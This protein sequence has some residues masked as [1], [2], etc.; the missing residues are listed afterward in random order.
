MAEFFYEENRI[1]Y[2]QR[3]KTWKKQFQNIIEK[4]KDFDIIN[5]GI[6]H[7]ALTDLNDP[8]H[9][10]REKHAEKY[11]EA[12]RNSKKFYI[13]KTLSKNTEISEKNISKVYDYVFLN[14]YDLCGVYKRFDSDYDMA[15]SFRRLR[16]GKDIQEHDLIMLKHGHLEYGLMNKLGMSYEEAHKLSESKYN[17]AMALKKFKEEKGL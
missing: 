11:Y 3:R 10:K 13:V 4:D 5:L 6:T 16:D 12:V 7:G 9:V 17:Y 8:L 1:K 2:E 15:E 14:K